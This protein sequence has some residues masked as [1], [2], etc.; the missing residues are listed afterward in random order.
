MPIK[1][2]ENY[3]LLDPLYFCSVQDKLVNRRNDYLLKNKTNLVFTGTKTIFV[4]SDLE[5][6]L[7]IKLDGSEEIY[8][9]NLK[10]Y[11]PIDLIRKVELC[12]SD[13]GPYTILYYE[14]YDVFVKEYYNINLKKFNKKYEI[15]SYFLPQDLILLIKSYEYEIEEFIVPLQILSNGLKLVHYSDFFLLVYGTFKTDDLIIKVKYDTYININDVRL[16]CDQEKLDYY[17][18][19]TQY[20]IGSDYR[21]NFDYCVYALVITM[22]EGFSTK[23]L[24]LPYHV[25]NHANDASFPDVLNI[26]INGKPYVVDLTYNIA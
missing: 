13:G 20:Q 11:Y 6:N 24:G 17:F 21:L 2:L 22:S 5:D 15:L 14:S 1:S 26:K 12:K 7:F 19:Q 16:G 8:I 3:K 9:K 23:I 18:H 10:I 25:I 4:K